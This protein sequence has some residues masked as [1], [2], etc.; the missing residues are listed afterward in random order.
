MYITFNAKQNIFIKY[1]CYTVSP[2]KIEGRNIGGVLDLSQLKY[3]MGNLINGRYRG[4]GSD[5]TRI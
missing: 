4:T 1:I 3:I 5:E 2:T